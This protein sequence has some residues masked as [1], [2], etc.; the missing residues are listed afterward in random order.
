[1]PGLSDT[2]KGLWSREA[3]H[4]VV[5]D[6]PRAAVAPAADTGEPCVAG[7]HYFRLWLAEMRLSRDREWFTSRQP[8]VHSLVRLRFGDQ[9]LELPR[10]SGPLAIPALDAAHLG[11]VIQLDHPLTP[12]LPY[13]GGTVEL[14]AGL[15]ALE[16]ASV[17]RDFVTAVDA[18]SQVLVQPPLSGVLAAVTPITRAVQALL[19]ASSG[20]QH[21][22]I[23]LGYAG[24]QPP[25]ALHAGYIAIVRRDAREVEAGS[26]SVSE[27]RLRY[28]GAALSGADYLLFRVERLAERDDWDRLS[29]IARPFNEALA[30]LGHGNAPLADALVRRAVLEAFT[31][32]DLTRT[33]RPRVAAEVKRSY[34]DARNAGLGLA[35][36]AV[37]L[38]D[39]MST[40]PPPDTFRRAQ[41]ATLDS[42]LDMGN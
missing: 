4:Y 38:S 25:H 22:G 39:V 21:L 6:V 24:D 28:E 30:A 23:H 13:N 33:D 9:E 40:A 14:S 32:P 15:I 11:D 27:G 29:S 19:G 5:R 20:R 18:I 26:L 7:A 8:V 36:V 3:P 42:L 34:Q 37:S 2:I 12:L 1:M 35:H 17:I 41:P 10:V 31:S 16:G